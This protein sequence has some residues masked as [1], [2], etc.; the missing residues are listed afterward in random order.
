[1]SYPKVRLDPGGLATNRFTS[2]NKAWSVASLIEQAK[3]LEP[4]DL[5][6]CCVYVGTEIYVAA[7][8]TTAKALAEHYLRMQH[9]DMGAPIIL[10]AEGFVMDGW[11]RIAR[12]LAEGRET[13]KAVRFDV[14][15]EPHYY[16][17]ES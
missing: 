3:D 2:G 12:A 8:I 7:R 5:P 16:E 10:D 9:V 1:M 17:N 14:T 13:V 6:L 11:H 4:F 15:P